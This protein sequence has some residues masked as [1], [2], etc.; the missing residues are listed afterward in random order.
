MLIFQ[1]PTFWDCKW[2][3]CK[4][5]TL[6]KQ[7]A[8]SL[9]IT[10]ITDE[11]VL[12]WWS[13]FFDGQLPVKT[14]T[15]N[16]VLPIGCNFS[17]LFVPC[18]LG[19]STGDLAL[20]QGAVSVHGNLHPQWFHNL[21]W[22]LWNKLN[23]SVL[24]CEHYTSQSYDWTSAFKIWHYWFLPLTLSIAVDETLSAVKVISPASSGLMAL[25]VSEWVLPMFMFGDKFIR[26]TKVRN[27]TLRVVL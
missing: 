25:R 3:D 9:I 22:K 20:Q 6:Y 2:S 10:S 15:N 13:H 8:R 7:S 5:L 26:M 12:V 24:N 1:M 4:C 14:F 21:N 23:H 16:L 27:K 11:G 19:V 18:D 17:V